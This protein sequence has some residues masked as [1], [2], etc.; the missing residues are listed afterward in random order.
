MHEIPGRH[1]I[2]DQLGFSRFEILFYLIRQVIYKSTDI[3]HVVSSIF[4]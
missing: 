4:R 2:W 1:L 3:L